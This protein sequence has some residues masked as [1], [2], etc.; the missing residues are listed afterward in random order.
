MLASYSRLCGGNGQVAGL[1]LCNK[2]NR[3]T[4]L[5]NYNHYLRRSE[6]PDLVGHDGK[7]VGSDNKTDGMNRHIYRLVAAVLAAITIVSC[8]GARKSETYRL[9]EDV[10]S[11]I[12]ARP[13]SALAVLEGIDKSELTSKELEAK[14]ALLL[15]QALDKNYIDLQSDSIIAPAVRYYENHGTPDERLK[16]YYYSGR[17]KQNSGDYEGAMESFV[18]GEE[19]AE[20]CADKVAAARLYRAKMAINQDIFNYAQ[21]IVDANNAAK[22]YLAGGDNRRYCNTILSLSILY[23]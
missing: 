20:R 14:Y 5:F 7:R 21:A 9:L 15:S 18:K 16:M 4:P 3:A 12:E 1:A 6:M 17:I 10:D 22:Y 19:Y 23:H 13:D 8:N 2:G 11:Y